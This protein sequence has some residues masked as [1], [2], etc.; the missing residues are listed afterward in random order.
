MENRHWSEFFQYVDNIAYNKRSMGMV[1][2]VTPPSTKSLSICMNVP[3]FFVAIKNIDRRKYRTNK[4]SCTR[5]AH[6]YDTAK[7]FEALF[8]TLFLSLLLSV[9]LFVSLYHL[10]DVRI[11]ECRFEFHDHIRILSNGKK[12]INDKTEWREFHGCGERTKWMSVDW[13]WER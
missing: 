5:H 7:L 13:K 8:S 1:Y 9:C 10:P 12:K 2:I 4:L 6:I 3:Y 11:A